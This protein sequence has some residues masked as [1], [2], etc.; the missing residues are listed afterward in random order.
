M[1]SVILERFDA[2]DELRSFEKGT[3]ALVH[4]GCLNVPAW[5]QPKRRW[6]C[7]PLRSYT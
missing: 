6:A 2:P 1:N 4:L 3:F 5:K 7:Y